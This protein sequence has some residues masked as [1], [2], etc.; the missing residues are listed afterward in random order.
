M[1]SYRKQIDAID[2]KMLSLLSQRFAAAK[3]IGA[4]KKKRGIAI[5]DGIREQEIKQLLSARVRAHGLDPSFISSL[6]KRILRE[7]RRIQ[8]LN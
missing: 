8:N 3:K 4:Y 6:W 2:R 1:T 5:H 7:S